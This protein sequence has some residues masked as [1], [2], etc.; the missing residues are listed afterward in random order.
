MRADE[1]IVPYAKIGI[2][3]GAGTYLLLKRGDELQG[4]PWRTKPC[5]L[6]HQA[7]ALLVFSS[8]VSINNQNAA[9]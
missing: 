9:R 7:K 8:G 2:Y 6:T 5:P 1:D 4:T 3:K